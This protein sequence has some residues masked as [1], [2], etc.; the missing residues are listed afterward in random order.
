MFR[1]DDP[2]QWLR[3][4]YGE[5]FEELTIYDQNTPGLVELAREAAEQGREVFALPGPVGSPLSHGTNELIRD[6]A[7][8]VQGLDDILEHLGE[9]GAKMG[10]EEAPPAVPPGLNETETT[11]HALLTEGPLS[12][13][14]LVRR[15]GLTSAQV[16]SGMTMLVLKGAV[17]QQPG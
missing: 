17:S 11:L 1:P 13:D 6:G 12:V 10:V 2:E 15:S 5:K 7:V 9:V 3:T 4:Y 16:A 8:L 14:D